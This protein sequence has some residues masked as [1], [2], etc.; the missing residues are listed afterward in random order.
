Q[1]VELRVL[2]LAQVFRSLR[3]DKHGWLVVLRYLARPCY[4]LRRGRSRHDVSGSNT[5][6]HADRADQYARNHRASPPAAPSSSSSSSAPLRTSGSS[7]TPSGASASPLRV[8]RSPYRLGSA[9]ASN[10][11][12]A[13]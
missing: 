3:L 11:L 8:T 13:S 5:C 12:R 7:T 6:Q 2:E 10:H 1:T 9:F 4:Q